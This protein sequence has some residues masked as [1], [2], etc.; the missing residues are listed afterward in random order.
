MTRR[1]AGSRERPAAS[2]DLQI[3]GRNSLA[4]VAFADDSMVELVRLRPGTRW[5]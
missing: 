3:A 1:S 2:H 4:L 5:R